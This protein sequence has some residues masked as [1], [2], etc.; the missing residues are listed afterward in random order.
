MARIEVYL[1]TAYAIALASPRDEHHEKA[2]LLADQLE[3]DGAK[4]ITTRAIILEIGNALSKQS[5]RLAGVELLESLE[6]DPSVE[7]VP[8]TEEL[9]NR[10]FDL[11]QQRVDKEWGITDCISFI[12]MAERDL[13]EALTTDK[14]FEQAGY[15][16]LL[17]PTQE[18]V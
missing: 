12:V 2:L 7:I 6:Q 4:L 13:R 11:Y 9:Y 8:L 1:D 10:A 17:R 15:K 18:G 14:H 5:H 3:E 16:A